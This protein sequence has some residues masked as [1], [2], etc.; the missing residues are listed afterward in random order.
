MS[1]LFLLNGIKSPGR[2]NLLKHG[3]VNLEDLPDDIAL[4]IY[5]AGCPFLI[6]SPEGKALLYPDVVQVTGEGIET[7]EKVPR[8]RKK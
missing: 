6:P 4:E 8:K 1:R 2:V 5:Q 3:T 7:V